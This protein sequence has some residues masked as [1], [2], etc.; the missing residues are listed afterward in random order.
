MSVNP[1]LSLNEVLGG[2]AALA[3]LG[4]ET[5]PEQQAQGSKRREWLRN[6]GY[7]L[8]G[9]VI[10]MVA[11]TALVLTL[12][13]TAPVLALAAASVGTSG[14][15]AGLWRAFKLR[16]DAKR[17]GQPV[18][19][20]REAMK[21]KEANRATLFSALGGSLF[22]G[23]NMQF[24]L[25]HKIADGMQAVGHK[26]A[27]AFNAMSMD[28]RAE[29]LPLSQPVIDAR[30]SP[31]YI[32]HP[33]PSI[34]ARLIDGYMGHPDAGIDAR[35]MD[36]YIGHPQ[37]EVPQGGGVVQAALKVD[38]AP[39]KAEDLSWLP[40]EH[41][42][43]SA[44][45]EDKAFTPLAPQEVAAPDDLINQLATQNDLPVDPADDP[46]QLA[47]AAPTPMPV[48]T[49]TQGINLL[50]EP[51][52][53]APVA[54]AVDVQA[55]EGATTS[56][57]AVPQSV[58]PQQ[59]VDAP[60]QPVAAPLPADPYEAAA[61]GGKKIA[62]CTVREPLHN[63]FGD[64]PSYMQPASSGADVEL[65]VTCKK[66][67][68]V[69]QPGDYVQWDIRYEN[70]RHGFD[71]FEARTVKEVIPGPTA[72]FIESAWKDVTSKTMRMINP[73]N[74]VHAFL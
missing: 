73:K 24:D 64:L 74:A 38:A 14:A 45:I 62:E 51:E 35:L 22:Q 31:D 6:G 71:A 54:D 7:M 18:P 56:P 28:V 65:N 59:E 27:D 48:A 47:S 8:G 63:Q 36:G 49:E 67:A 42:Q 16:R 21:S 46:V 37:P 3:P 15:I 23:I 68:E 11:H 43:P 4:R 25:G 40:K 30:L 69:A 66:F 50:P 53:A 61:E 33:Q 26:I 34:D 57:E 29:M 12:P 9:A 10:S 44:P 70:I 72:D 13:T 41:S 2:A 5:T 55:I 58:E 20:F 17:D 19:S 60:A 1:T 39:P 32:G 52:M